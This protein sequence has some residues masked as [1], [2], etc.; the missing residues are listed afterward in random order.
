MLVDITWN[1]LFPPIRDECILIICERRDFPLICD[2]LSWSMLLSE[3][4]APL[5][6]YDFRLGLFIA[7]AWDHPSWRAMH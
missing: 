1:L 2:P 7:T 3:T 4:A 5:T 6:S